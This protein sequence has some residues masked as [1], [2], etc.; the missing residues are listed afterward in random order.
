MWESMN[1]RMIMVRFPVTLIT[2]VRNKRQKSELAAVRPSVNPNKMNVVMTVWFH[3][4]L[5]CFMWS[6]CNKVKEKLFK[7]MKRNNKQ[8]KKEENQRNGKEKQ[9]R[10]WI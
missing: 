10:R 2:Y 3:Y 8:K 6:T 9:E 4:Q 1:V 5:W 7:Q